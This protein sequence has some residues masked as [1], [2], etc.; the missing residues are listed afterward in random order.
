M[1]IRTIGGQRVRVQIE[2]IP[3]RINDLD[4]LEDATGIGTR[5][6][7]IDVALSF[8]EWAVREAQDGRV[9]ASVDEPEGHYVVPPFKPLETAAQRARSK[10]K[11]RKR[12]RRIV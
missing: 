2:M 4:R 6:E 5:R 11:D 10:R 9:I 8:F 7:L 12:L 3:E 1:R